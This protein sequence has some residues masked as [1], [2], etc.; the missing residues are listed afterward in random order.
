[1]ATL[2]RDGDSDGFALECDDPAS[3]AALTELYF[4][5][6][7]GR[8]VRRFPP[9]SVTDAIFARFEAA[10]PSLLRQTARLEPAP[11]DDALHETARRLDDAGVDW[12]LTGSSALAVRG[13]AV[14]PR[15]LDLVVSEADAA[16]AATAFEDALI[17]PAVA[18]EEWFCRWWGRAWLG[19]R[20]EWV[21][22]VT[23]A[24]DRPEPT[25][26]G[27]VAAAALSDVRWE[28]R[29]IRLPPLELQR[30]VSARRGLSDRVR[31]IVT[32][33]R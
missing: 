33:G 1:M 27:P 28:G 23:E 29:A 8:Y 32:L 17:E 19:A 9:G 7:E 4:R 31:L 2:L 6:E 3:G 11:W 15:D 22:G 13:L 30:Q 5:L 18:V 20:V 21:G 14:S 10:L 12:W 25:D 26:F 16:R 24:A